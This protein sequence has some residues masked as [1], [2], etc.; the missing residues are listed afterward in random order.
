MLSVLGKKFSRGH[1]KIF[2]FSPENK[3][4]NWHFVQ[5]VP[6]GDSLQE[7]SKPTFWENKKT[8]YLYCL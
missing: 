2:L 3:L 7:I 8:I 5:I 6:Q 1:F 4:S